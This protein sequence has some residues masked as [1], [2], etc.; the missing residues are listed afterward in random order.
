MTLT[1][2]LVL[3][4]PERPDLRPAPEGMTVLE[5][6]LQSGL[7][8]RI[9][10]TPELTLVVSVATGAPRVWMQLPPATIVFDSTT[11]GR[12]RTGAINPGENALSLRFLLLAGTRLIGTA[13]PR[14]GMR[15]LL[16]DIGAP[17]IE[18][19]LLQCV[20]TA[21]AVR[22]LPLTGARLRMAWRRHERRTGPA[23]GDTSS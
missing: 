23:P 8:A 20:M 4:L 22:G 7:P 15:Q 19:A 11:E 5:T 3:P 17:R 18:F 2:H 16:P 21:G 14:T 12:P 6:E 9:P 10:L 1:D 13:A